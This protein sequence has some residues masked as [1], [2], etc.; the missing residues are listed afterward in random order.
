MDQHKF[1][2]GGISAPEYLPWTNMYV[3][4]TPFKKLYLLNGLHIA[5]FKMALA[6]LYEML[7]LQ[8]F[9]CYNLKTNNDLWILWWEGLEEILWAQL[10]SYNLHRTHRICTTC[11]TH[12][13]YSDWYCQQDHAKIT[14]GNLRTKTTTILLW[15]QSL[16]F[17][18]FTSCV[19]L[20]RIEF[21]NGTKGNNSVQRL[22]F[23]ETIKGSE[24]SSCSL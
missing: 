3:N 1:R 19:N 6:E 24:R 16:R 13:R 4:C 23:K 10:K 14:Q 9:C 20:K 22:T 8:S 5:I 2:Q 21:M 7:T 18:T 11:E 15:V 12:W 17:S